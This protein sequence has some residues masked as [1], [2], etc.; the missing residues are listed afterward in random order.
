MRWYGT[1]TEMRRKVREMGGHDWTG[2]GCDD[3]VREG[4]V[5][6]KIGESGMERWRWKKGGEINVE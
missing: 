6:E 1:V 3:G 5:G 4:E 2:L